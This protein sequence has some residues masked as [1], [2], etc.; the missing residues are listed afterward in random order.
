[1]AATFFFVSS[2]AILGQVHAEK[3]EAA[4]FDQHKYL[5]AT[6]AA[7]LFSYQALR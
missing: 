5:Y 7:P 4:Q 3:E 2:T 6:T 1:M